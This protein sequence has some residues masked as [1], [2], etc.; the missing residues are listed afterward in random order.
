MKIA[1]LKA[2]AILVVC[3]IFLSCLMLFQA[4]KSKHKIHYYIAAGGT[5]GPIIIAAIA[6]VMEQIGLFFLSIFALLIS[7]S[8][9]FAI[10]R[11]VFI[12]D[13]A[14]DLRNFDA[15]TPLCFNDF[16]SSWRSI[17]KLEKK[18][19]ERKTLTIH[20]L[21]NAG[22]IG[23]G[24]VVAYWLL[25]DVIS[26]F[27]GNGLLFMLSCSI[28][29][30]IGSFSGFFMNYRSIKKQLKQQ[31]NLSI[32]GGEQ[33]FCTACGASKDKDAVYC[34]KCGKKFL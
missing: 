23:L 31:N 4:K 14:E 16:F 27:H 15:S 33:K 26:T 25:I 3:A 34:P 17:I 1:L 11:P 21:L 7:C 2:S 32:L 19:G 30:S 29:A 6:T 22:S 10:S 5:S 12:K 28:G 13:I 20:L 24:L 9:I 18:Y 8:I